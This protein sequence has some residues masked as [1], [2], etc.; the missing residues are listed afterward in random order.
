MPRLIEDLP[1]FEKLVYRWKG[2]RSAL[3]DAIEAD[4]D[5][6]NYEQ[7]LLAL[8]HNA[9]MLEAS[10][11]PAHRP[12]DDGGRRFIG[13]GPMSS[14]AYKLDKL[15]EQFAPMMVAFGWEDIG[16][17]STAIAAAAKDRSKF[18]AAIEK[19]RQQRQR[20]SGTQLSE[21]Q[22]D[23][24]FRRTWDHL[25]KVRHRIYLDVLPWFGPALVD[26]RKR[27]DDE[28][29][30]QTQ[31]RADREWSAAMGIPAITS[32]ETLECAMATAV[33]A[34][35]PATDEGLRAWVHLRLRESVPAEV[36]G[37]APD[38]HVTLLQ[39][40]G[41]VNRSKRT[42]E[43]FTTKQGFPLP[44][45]QGT[46]GKP[47]EW[48]WSVVRPLLESEYGRNLPEIFPGDRFAKR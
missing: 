17:W 38:C 30:K 10:W 43:R 4:P 25:E 18:R 26:A 1:S 12:L 20:N 47:S 27:H 29:V 23:Q 35:F 6:R 3:K 5:S 41:I 2:F 21:E 44:D 32:L 15:D 7:A 28:A 36:Q 37:T 11:N 42:L 48:R 9:F 13:V 14:A 22:L 19:L 31:M 33:A 39:M 46:G 24:A 45:V 34:G 8:A 16:T 40:A